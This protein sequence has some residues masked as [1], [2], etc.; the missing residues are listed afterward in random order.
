MLTNRA[1]VKLAKF[2][3]APCRKNYTLDRKM[4]DTFFDGHDEL[5]HHAKFGE[6]GTMPAGC[7]YENVVFVFFYRQDAAKRQP[8]GIVFTQ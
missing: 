7:R 5:Y 3:R 6:D 1:S 4:D 2:F 8:A